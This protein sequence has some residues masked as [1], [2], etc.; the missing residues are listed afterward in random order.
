LSGTRQSDRIQAPHPETATYHHFTVD[1]EEHFQVS[2]LE[3]FVARS[4]W[5]TLPSR[6]V[7]STM[8]LLDLLDHSDARG[9][10]FIL[11][12]VAERYPDLV[13]EIASRGHEVASHGTDHKRVTQ[14]SHTEFRVSIRDSKRVLED[15]AGQSVQGYRAPSFSIVPGLEWALDILLEE[16]YCYDSSLYPVRHPR[17]GY[18]SVAGYPHVIHRPTG[19]I[20]EFPP[21]TLR[22]LGAKLPAGG[23]AYLRLLPA[24]LL[25]AALQQA[26]AQRYPATAYIHP[27]E[28]DPQQPRFAVPLLTRIRHYGGLKRTYS[29]LED[30]LRRFSF[31]PIADSL[32]RVRRTG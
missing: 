6:V 15:I 28:V 24:Y 5:N 26:E 17:Y 2:A 10:F 7:R 22:F 19:R 23:G 27:W 32:D 21:A 4:E 11:S 31:R 14:L 1:V 8:K 30:L 16:G 29:R 9:T 3:P 18:P 12:W 20:V 13:R 25:H